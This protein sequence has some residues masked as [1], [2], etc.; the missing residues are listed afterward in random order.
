MPLM[1][2]EA[3][4]EECDEHRREEE[5]FAPEKERPRLELGPLG[6]ASCF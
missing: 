6:G 4:P 5:T 3:S 1:V 2:T